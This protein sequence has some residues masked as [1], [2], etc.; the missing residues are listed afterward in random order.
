MERVYSTNM[1]MDMG[2]LL[3]ADVTLGPTIGQITR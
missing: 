1:D 2:T 3:D